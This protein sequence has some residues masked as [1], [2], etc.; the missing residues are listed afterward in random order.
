M[1]SSKKKFKKEL[2]IYNE[3]CKYIPKVIEI[4]FNPNEIFD[5]HFRLIEHII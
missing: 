5:I 3:K 2:Y 4:I 1:V